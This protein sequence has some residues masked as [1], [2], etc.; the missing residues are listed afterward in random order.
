MNT[1]KQMY[2]CKVKAFLLPSQIKIISSAQM[3]TFIFLAL[4][5]FAFFMP[6]KG[7][8]HLAFGAPWRPVVAA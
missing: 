5:G 4:V 3:K 6:P 8:V 7:S 1:P 2:R